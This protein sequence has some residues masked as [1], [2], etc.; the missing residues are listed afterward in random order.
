MYLIIIGPR[1]YKL[2]DKK[3]NFQKFWVGIE[4]KLFLSLYI[5]KETKFVARKSDI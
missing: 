3:L 1:N 2:V 4:E 5:F